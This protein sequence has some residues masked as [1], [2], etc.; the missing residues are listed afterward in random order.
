MPKWITAIFVF[1]LSTTLLTAKAITVEDVIQKHVEVIS[2]KV[3]NQHKDKEIFADYSRK[4]YNAKLEGI[5]T[6]AGKP[7][8]KI[9]FNIASGKKMYYFI[10]AESW[11]IIRRS[12]SVVGKSPDISTADGRIRQGNFNTSSVK[13]RG[14]N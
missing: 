6:V 8:Y 7:C 14:N 4:G 12:E 9:S 1:F 11:Y 10:D 3:D 5:E 13:G 2:S